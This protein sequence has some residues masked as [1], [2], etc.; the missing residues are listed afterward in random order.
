MSIDQRWLLR[1]LV[2]AALLLA[3][4]LGWERVR[5]PERTG[6]VP[7]VP[8]RPEVVARMLELAAVDGD[9]LVFDLGS[10][11]GRI[12]IHAAT[13]YGARGR[14]F[15]IDPLLV[16]ESRRHASA[17]G[18][19][20]RAEF[21][22]G[23][24]FDADLGDATAVTLYLLPT[25]NL[26][27]RARLFAQLAPGT[28]VVSQAFDMAEWQPD[29]HEVMPL[30]PPAD[31]YLWTIPA[32]VGGVWDL[33][34]GGAPEDAPVV[35]LLQRFQEL[36]GDLSWGTRSVPLTGTV[37]GALVTLATTR[38]HPVLG[39]LRLVGSVA[40]ERLDG[41]AWAMSSDLSEG[42]GAPPGPRRFEAVRRP[43][44]VEGVWSVGPVREPFAPH[45]WLRLRRDGERWTATRWNDDTVAFEAADRLP[46]TPGAP[47]P[48]A[49]R[50]RPMT[51]LY[52]LGSSV[53]FVVGAA[54]G[55]PRRV[56][57]HGLVEGDGISG[58]IHDGGDL[59]PWMAVRG[60]EQ[61]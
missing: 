2:A 46:G 55:S 60:G 53:S 18:V 24:L 21:V 43:A 40:G 51:D 31:L 54:D 29:R 33:R 49:S 59:V 8:T 39:N 61:R 32:G 42:E 45:W 1:G 14:G 12:V 16:R 48:A 52:V 58:M 47:S 35:R 37:D 41:E 9:D 25:V 7:Y 38:A 56:A 10:G 30:D 36:E 20:D 28:P 26:S 44:A 4:G 23:N 5:V 6:D 3:I 11:D 13:E 57:Y 15:E 19:S 22:E 27:L 50:E 17:A 34:V